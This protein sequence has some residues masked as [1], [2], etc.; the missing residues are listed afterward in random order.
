MMITIN[1]SGMAFGPFGDDHCFDIEICLAYKG[2]ENGVKIADF[3]WLRDDLTPPKIWIVE[4]KSSTPRPQPPER[5]HEF[6]D[7]IQGKLMNAFSMVLSA[8][9]NRP[10]S[11]YSELPKS[12]LQVDLS[13]LDARFIPVIHNHEK[14][15]L[16][17]LK[18]ALAKALHATVKTWGLTP[19]AVL[20]LNDDLAR[21]H[22]LIQ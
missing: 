6:I 20:V 17:P 5:F 15:W 21:R 19:P 18:D 3:I 13:T 7:E 4:A 2:I 16:P 8:C 11:A 1:E 14:A 22:K 10:G 9:L 12:F